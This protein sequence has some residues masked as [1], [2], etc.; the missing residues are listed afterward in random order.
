MSRKKST[1]GGPARPAAAV[2]EGNPKVELEYECDGRPPVALVFE[3]CAAKYPRTVDNF[4]QLVAGAG[5]ADKKNKKTATYSHTPLHRC[6]DYMVQGGD[7]TCVVDPA[8]LGQ[9]NPPGWKGQESVWGGLF[10]D[11]KCWDAFPNRDVF[12]EESALESDAKDAKDVDACKKLCL[13]RGFGGFSVKDGKARFKQRTASECCS[14]VEHSEGCTVHSFDFGPSALKHVAGTL[15]MANSGPDTNGSQYVITT[16]QCAWLDGRH[17]AFG[18]LVSGD[19][20]ALHQHMLAGCDADGVTPR[21]S[22]CYVK[23]V[24]V[25]DPSPPT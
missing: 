3:L 13:E 14:H 6:T 7:V 20:N 18:S 23:S 21:P 11:E 8:A 16:K 12:P 2:P 10:D 15:S 19:L 4:K 25:L 1:A 5:A 17:T 9:G 24:S 22:F